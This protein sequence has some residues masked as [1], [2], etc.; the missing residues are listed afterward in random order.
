MIVG[1]CGY[2][3]IQRGHLADYRILRPPS[4]LD[5][6]AVPIGTTGDYVQGQ[7]RTAVRSSS[8]MGDIVEH[9]QR[10]AAGMQG[11][12]FVTDRDT[13][14]EVADR[15]RAAGV[16]AEFISHKTTDGVRDSMIRRFRAGNLMQLVNIDL[17]GEGFDVPAVQVV[18]FGRPTESYAVYSQQFGRALRPPGPALILDH[19]G[20]TLRHGLPDMPRPWTLDRRERRSRAG[21]DVIPVRVC[22]QCESVY[23]RIHRICPYCGHYPIPAIRSGPEHVDGDLE[24]LDAATLDRMRAELAGVDATTGE[25]RARLAAKR[26]PLVGQM[27]GVKRHVARQEAQAGLRD[28]IA[29]WAGYQ[30]HAGR[31]DTESY[32][33]F[34]HKFGVD[35]LTAQTLGAKEAAELEGRVRAH[36]GGV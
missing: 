9:Y 3:L 10:H 22:P 18:S 4:D 24:E 36:M 15:Y 21:S 17:F 34:Y 29:L 35:V 5:V 14:A 1:P 27:A 32:R 6:S 19:V 11:I 2:D 33:R 26:V 16:P 20:N 30:R 8:I 23:E 28:A 25:E 31:A 12:T 13:G 7:L